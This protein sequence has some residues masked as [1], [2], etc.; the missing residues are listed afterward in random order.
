[1]MRKE[2]R[3][4]AAYLKLIRRDTTA[5][6]PPSRRALTVLHR[7]AYIFA[8]PSGQDESYLRDANHT[9]LLL[10]LL[11]PPLYVLLLLQGRA[12]GRLVRA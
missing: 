11:S 5:R 12:A 1:M 8:V 6:S 9:L 7:H 10:L 3:G 4:A 2:P